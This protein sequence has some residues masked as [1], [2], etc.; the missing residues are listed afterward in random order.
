MQNKLVVGSVDVEGLVRELKLATQGL[1]I[2]RDI[3]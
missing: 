1:C 2:F 3:E